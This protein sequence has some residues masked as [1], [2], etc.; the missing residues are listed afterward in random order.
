MRV[1]VAAPK[2][3]GLLL[4][5]SNKSDEN[6]LSRFCKFMI[7]D[8]QTKRE[9]QQMYSSLYES[10][11]WVLRVFRYL[12]CEWPKQKVLSQNSGDTIKVKSVI[13]LEDEA[14]QEQ[15]RVCLLTFEPVCVCMRWAARGGLN[16]YQLRWW[17][18]RALD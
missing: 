5:T 4:D 16:W 18:K 17:W 12:C 10:G 3:D 2:L 7:R 6:Q 14:Y 13:T 11:P 1:N 9:Q 15:E 8:R